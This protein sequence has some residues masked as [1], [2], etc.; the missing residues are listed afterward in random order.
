[1]LALAPWLP[2]GE[3]TVQLAGRTVV[4]AHGTR[5]HTTSPARSLAYALAARE[6]CDRLCRFE[7][8]GSRHAMLAR[9]RTWQRLVR[10]AV[11]AA[12]ELRPWDERLL[13]A[14]ALPSPAGCR[15]PL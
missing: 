14:F 11:P 10:R 6:V 9:G 13:E 8:A 1:V 12:L 5:D 3:P 2:P 4:I 15:V 7:V